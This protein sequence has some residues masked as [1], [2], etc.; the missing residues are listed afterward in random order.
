[1]DV[2]LVELIAF[3]VLLV[4]NGWALNILI[5]GGIV[6]IQVAIEP[7]FIDLELVIGREGDMYP[8]IASDSNSSRP[9]SYLMP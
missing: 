1:L 6:V 8:S 3:S 7:I 2:D 5:V 9:P 4:Y